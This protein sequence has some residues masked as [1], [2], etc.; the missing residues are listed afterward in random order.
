M[1]GVF[2]EGDRV[3]NSQTIA[4]FKHGANFKTHLG[5]SMPNQT[6]QKKKTVILH[7][8][9]FSRLALQVWLYEDCTCPGYDSNMKESPDME[10][11]GTRAPLCPRELRESWLFITEDN[12][13]VS[14]PE[15][16][17]PCF[18]PGEKKK[19]QLNCKVNPGGRQ[20]SQL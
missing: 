13:Q 10:L 1:N 9:S 14:S 3:G 4:L 5:A 18:F 19:E 20:Y 8:H 6:H 16:W 7:A 11:S 12:M 17:Q 2:L 15:Y